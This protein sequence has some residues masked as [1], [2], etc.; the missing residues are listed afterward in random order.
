MSWSGPLWPFCQRQLLVL[1]PLVPDAAAF[2]D[3]EAQQSLEI[4][5]AALTT[6]ETYIFGRLKTF[7]VPFASRRPSS[8]LFLRQTGRF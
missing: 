7:K 8:Y 2:A 4:Q 3:V 5:L 6:W 1:R